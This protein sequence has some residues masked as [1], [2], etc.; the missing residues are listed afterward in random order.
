MKKTGLCR[1]T[2]TP[3]RIAIFYALLSALW[4]LF[5]DTILLSLVSDPQ[6]LS[7]LQTYK[8]WFFVLVTASLLFAVMSDMI[9]RRN[10]ILHELRESEEYNHLLLALSPIGLALSRMDGTL[11]DINSA[12]A[13]II[14]R[15]VEETLLLSHGDIT[16]QQYVEQE[17]E[18]LKSLEETG[19][20]G[21][22]EQEYIHK[23][24][25]LVP[26]RL[27]GVVIERA[28]EKFIWSSIEDISEKKKAENELKRHAQVLRLFVEHTPAAVAMFDHD[29]KYI[30]A[31]RRF[32]TDYNLADRDII[33]RFHYDVVPDVPERWKEIYRRCLAGAVEKC[34]ED[35][36]PR[37]DGKM[38]WVHWECRPWHES[39][40]KIGGIILFSEVITERKEAE[41]ALRLS[42]EKFAMTFRNCPEAIA[43]TS[44]ANGQF[45]E[46]NE[47][48]LDL[49]GY[50]LDEIIGHTT[51]D[52]SLWVNPADRLRYLDLLRESGR[53]TNMET[54]FQQKSGGIL[55]SLVSGELIKVQDSVYILTV[56][57]DITERKQAELELKRHQDHLEELVQ[58]RTAALEESKRALMNIVEDLHLKTE[59]LGQANARLKELDRL[60]SMF[61]ASM[62]HELRTPLNS[63]IGFTGLIVGDMAGAI[64]DEQRDMLERVSRAGKHL[65]S[66]ITDVI[67]IA[68]IES[69][70]I[71]PYPEDFDLQA[72]LDEAVD[73]VRAQAG[74]KGIAIEVLLPEPPL[75]IHSDRKRLLQCL[76]NYLSNAVKFSEKGTVT[77]EV[78][79]AAAKGEGTEGENKRLP[80][81]WL[82]IS[83]TD[84]GIGIR[85]E[86]MTLLFGSFVRLDT[87]L[88]TTIPGTGL[89]LYLTRKLTTEVL[90][91]TVGAESEE[92]RGSRFWLRIPMVSAIT[93]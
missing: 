1:D 19:R 47:S 90:G 84:T 75:V 16:P 7:R 65:L 93:K 36:L 42:E 34:E 86:D 12:Y 30:V 78:K 55:I 91:G 4:I 25:Y 44:A 81:G 63:I 20:Y 66:L 51:L 61:I 38:D 2:W 22:Y 54:D 46:V 71:T 8:G 87:P 74:E 9:S 48:F 52:L 67:D 24:G 72:L 64:S 26:V 49:S 92:G 14:G 77:V 28:G 17:R 32:L 80:E 57:R 60:K 69:G 79:T 10:M 11:V 89:G 41:A 76:L 13:R 43:L 37:A 18:Q 23:E 35:L 39:Q 29:M 82:E 68:K 62:S 5:S 21:P 70:K 6:V 73:Q 31:S 59:E 88:K 58:D 45:M 85:E 56:I 15:S 83:V 53:V 27:Q 3:L 50:S 33:G 40:G